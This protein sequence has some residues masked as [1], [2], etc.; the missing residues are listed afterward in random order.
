MRRHLGLAQTALVGWSQ[1]I[2]PRQMGRPETLAGMK[3]NPCADV[4]EWWHNLRQHHE[5]HLPL[6]TRSNYDWR[7]RM[8]QVSA[9]ALVIHGM[10][11]LIPVESSR[12]WVDILLSRRPPR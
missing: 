8:S 5:T 2:V 10:E 11:D 4:N 3:S 1:V 9:F 6:E 12:A 7:E